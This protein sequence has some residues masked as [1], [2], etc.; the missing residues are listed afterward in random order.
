M[1]IRRDRKC[2]VRGCDSGLILHYSRFNFRIWAI[3]I[4]RIEESKVNFLNYEIHRCI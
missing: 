2:F 1:K 3:L 4:G